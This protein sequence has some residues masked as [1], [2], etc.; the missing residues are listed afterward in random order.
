MSTRRES[1]VGAYIQY[2]AATGRLYFPS[3]IMLLA[4]VS[5]LVQTWAVR[6]RLGG[7]FLQVIDPLILWGLFRVI[8]PFLLWGYFAASIYVGSRLL[9]G[10]PLLGHVIRVVAWGFPPFIFA[11]LVWGVG[12]YYALGDATLEGPDLM[13]MEH[14]WAQLNDF[15]AQG[16]GEPIMIGA[17]ALGSLLVVC[18][19][20]LWAVGGTR[21]CDLELRRMLVV[22]AVPL[23]A[24]VCW[25]FGA[26]F[27][28]FPGP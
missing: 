2:K 7:D 28:V 25:R 3:A 15:L 23:L 21:A 26:I 8:E 12:Q 19:G 18:S 13:G 10:A 6:V 20:Y 14:D 27:G 4:S 17:T 1:H 11:G 5:F 9:G 24:Y 16:Y 22:V